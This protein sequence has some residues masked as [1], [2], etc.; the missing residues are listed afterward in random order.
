MPPRRIFTVRTPLGYRV[1]LSRDRWLQIIQFKHPA[2][3]GHERNVR[4]C[5]ETPSLIR[6]SAKE[7][8]VH[9]YYVSTDRG[10]LCVV[11]APA[12]NAARFVVTAYFTKNIKPGTELW[13]S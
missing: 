9:L 7:P 13:K 4:A 8:D 6:E 10:Y 5:L 1:F 12:D 2:L 11:T 3:A